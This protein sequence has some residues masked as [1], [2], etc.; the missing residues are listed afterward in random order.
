[1][2]RADAL[3]GETERFQVAAVKLV[4]PG[5]CAE[6]GADHRLL[7][8]VHES[9]RGPMICEEKCEL[10]TRYALLIAYLVPSWA[11]CTVT[12]VP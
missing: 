4:N 6:H 8:C 12:R 10:R 3:I 7:L 9:N 5:D 2:D 11:M 1:V